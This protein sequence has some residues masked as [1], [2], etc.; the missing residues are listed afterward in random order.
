MSSCIARAPGPRPPCRPRR[1]CLNAAAKSP[2]AAGDEPPPFHAPDPRRPVMNVLITGGSGFIGSNLVRLVLAE[3]PGWRVVNL[4]KLPYAG[5]AESVGELEGN[6]R[7]RFVRDDIANG[8]LVAEV[9]R[10]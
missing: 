2:R 8:E 9:F 10:T 4:D 7:Y 3:R 5:N 6:P 1:S